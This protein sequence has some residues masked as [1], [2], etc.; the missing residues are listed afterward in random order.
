MNSNLMQ[1]VV[2][3]TGTPVYQV[4]QA[5]SSGAAETVVF[6]KEVRMGNYVIQTVPQQ[7]GTAQ[8]EVRAVGSSGQW[9]TRS[10]IGTPI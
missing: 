10:V 7:D 4:P 3:N 6:A 1:L 5:G 9:Q 2:D 8:L